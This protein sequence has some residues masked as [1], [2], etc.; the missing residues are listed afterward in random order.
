V[1]VVL[2]TY[3][4]RENIV[5]VLT[6]VRSAVPE[7]H[8]LVIDDGS[9]DGTADV[10]E[11]LADELGKIEVVRRTAKDGLGSAYRFAFGRIFTRC[12]GSDAGSSDDGAADEADVVVTMDSDL[13]HDPLV[14]PSMIGAISAGA[15]AVIGSRYVAGGGTEN[16]PIHR[17]LLSRWGNRYTGWIL[18]IPV[19]DCTSGFRAY[20][21][22][23]LR[24]IRPETTSAEGYAF[25]TELVVRLC[26]QGC[27]IEEIP[28]LFVDRT[29]GTSKMSRQ[30]IVESM[31]LVTRWGLRRRLGRQQSEF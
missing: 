17:R 10:A 20:R 11:E 9:P 6:K 21:L 16:W 1:T 23:A 14:I 7:A 27:R 19:R 4:E 29:A 28:I 12:T 8:I 2:P 24:S 25:L 3:N 18:S 5:D 13:S 15:D 22:G 30:I 26:R 31:T